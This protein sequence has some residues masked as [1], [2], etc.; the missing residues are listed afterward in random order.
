MASVITN[1][2]NLCLNSVQLLCTSKIKQKTVNKTLQLDGSESSMIPIIKTGVN[3][4][5]KPKKGQD[6]VALEEF[7]A[8]TGISD[9]TVFTVDN[10]AIH[11]RIKTTLP[12]LTS[13]NKVDILAYILTKN[14]A[15]EEEVVSNFSQYSKVLIKKC[16]TSMSDSDI[17]AFKDGIYFANKVLKASTTSNIVAIEAKVKDWKSG[18]R[19]AM[20]YKEYADYSYLAIYESNVKTCLA[21]IAVF[22]NLG[23]GLIGVSNEGL[24]IYKFAEKTSDE[25]FYSSRLLATERFISLTYDGYEPFIVRNNL[26]RN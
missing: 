9:L 8:G 6:T 26:V 1:L 13:K 25:C 12:A 17:L 11:Q 2:Y 14:E 15:S 7:S 24:K 23:I 20:R 3:L 19:Q 4:L 21:N 10:R 22:E 16:L 18:I 5:S